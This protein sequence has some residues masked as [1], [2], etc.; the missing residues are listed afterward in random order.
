MK[1]ASQVPSYEHRERSAPVSIMLGTDEG[2]QCN[3]RTGLIIYGRADVLRV[4]DRCFAVP[5]DLL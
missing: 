3:H 5:F 4:H 1:G 2:G